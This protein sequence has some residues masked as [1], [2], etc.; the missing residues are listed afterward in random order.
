M[1]N[2]ADDP[3]GASGL[4]VT[5]FQVGIMAGSL[6][7]GLLYERSVALMLTASAGLMGCG[8]GRHRGQ[9]ADA[10]RCRRQA[11]AIHSCAVQRRQL[12]RAAG[13]RPA[14]EN[15]AG[16]RAMPHYFENATGGMHMSGWTR[17]GEGRFAALNAAGLASCHWRCAGAERGSRARRIPTR[18]PAIRAP[19]PR[20][21]AAAPPAPA[22]PPSAGPRRRRCPSARWPTG[23][24]GPRR[25][26][27]RD[28]VHRH[29]AVRAAEVRPG[30]R[31]DGGRGPADHHQLP[32]PG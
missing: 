24:R 25:R 9:P 17:A 7:G 20:R 13:R 11:H 8:A 14:A 1:R 32:R 31:L 4:Y 15:V 30:K 21:P 12:G 26:A 6:A 10:G 5:A 28:A 27:G 3:D 29:G 18:P 19:S 23:G 16:V 2:G 22:P